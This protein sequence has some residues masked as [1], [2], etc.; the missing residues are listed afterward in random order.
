MLESIRDRGTKKWTAMMLSEHVRELRIWKDKDNYEERPLLDDFDLQAI[1]YE[2]EVAYKR[3]CLTFVKSWENGKIILHSGVIKEI[4]VESMCI[5]IY[6]P[7]GKDR[8]LVKD[9]IGVRCEE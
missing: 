9:I 3:K 8:I 4:D 5:T 6:G 2:I 7:F 1:Q